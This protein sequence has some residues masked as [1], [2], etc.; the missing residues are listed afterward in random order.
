MMT[1]APE[2]TALI[3]DYVDRMRVVTPARGACTLEPQADA[4]GFWATSG[5]MGLTGVITEATLKLQPV[6]TSR[7]VS[8]TERTNDIDDCMARMLDRDH[9]YRYSVAW[10]DCLAPG[11]S[12]GR[13][14]L[15][16]GYHASLEE[17]G[18]R[19]RPTAS[20]FSPS[21]RLR[22][23][24]WLPNG[25]LNP[26]TI[27]AFNELWFRRAPRSEHGAIQSSRTGQKRSCARPSSV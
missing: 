3:N 26:V 16:R 1:V 22:A 23:P 8:D 18:A 10:I 25:L 24:R 6:E 15:T 14:V 7:I 9:E 27:R 17:L 4:N 13:S 5:G 12:L 2:A 11:A 21:T 19:D 20:V